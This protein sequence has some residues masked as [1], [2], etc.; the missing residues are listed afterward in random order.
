MFSATLN[1]MMFLFCCILVGYFL[2]KK[3]LLGDKPEG[4]IS[5]LENLVLIPCLL[6]NSFYKNCTI[7]SLSSNLDLL[8]YGLFFVL[9]QVGVAYCCLPLFKANNSEKGIFVYSMSVVNFSF[10]GNSLVSALF[11]SQMLYKY[12]IFSMPLNVLA[13]S[14]GYVWLSGD[15]FSF[16]KLINPIVVSMIIGIIL[17]LS[18]IKLPLFI[19]NT[20]SN[21]ANCFSP[22]AMIL[23]GLVI[24]GYDIKTLF[25]NK[26][27]YLL[28]C[29]RCIIL[30]FVVLYACR[31]MGLRSDIITLLIFICAMPLGLNTIV[32]P[33]AFG[34]DTTL[35]ASMALV[36]N[37]LG[38]ITVPMFLALFVV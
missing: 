26:R 35:G 28:T 27:V 13:F 36:S 21:L 17:G 14:I 10:M 37:I 25:T 20:I 12:L 23:T 1:Q 7:S 4:V 34:K 32:V 5:K 8:L 2:K 24:G 19:E 3:N 22:L 31:F 30:P 29:I 18:G 15:S 9:L 11:G 38:L 6:I 16:R 33:S